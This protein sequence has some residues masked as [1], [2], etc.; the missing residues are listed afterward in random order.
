[1]KGTGSMRIAASL[2]NFSLRISPVKAPSKEFPGE[3]VLGQN[4]P[5]PFNPATV[6]HYRLPAV[7]RSGASLYNVSLKIYNIVGQVVATVVNENQQSGAHTVTWDAS[8]MAS[9]VYFYRITVNGTAGAKS[10]ETARK[11]ALVR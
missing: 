4:Y 9:G 10:F 6:I 2:S 11:M 5:N 3:F 7:E 8:R 1:M